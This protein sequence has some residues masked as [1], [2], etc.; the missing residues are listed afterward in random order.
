MELE[1]ALDDTARMA[2]ARESVLSK[3][4]NVTVAAHRK[5]EDLVLEVERLQKAL[6]VSDSKLT[7]MAN[8]LGENET[9]MLQMQSERKKQLADVMQ[10]KHDA[11]SAALGEKN[12]H[13]AL[14]EV[15][16]K[17]YFSRFNL[18]LRVC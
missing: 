1:Q 18:E 15:K 13:I 3:H 10:M 4:G 17:R 12:A 6:K 2:A 16:L 8:Q 14:L 7:Q 11:L 5:V 9:K